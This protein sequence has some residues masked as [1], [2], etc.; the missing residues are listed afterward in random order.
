MNKKVLSLLGFASKAGKIGCGF[1][2]TLWSVKTKKA[3][4][5]VISD[6]ISEKSRKE[7]LFFAG[8]GNIKTTVLNGTDIQTI[9]NAVG[10][11]CGIVCVNDKGFADAILEANEV[12]EGGNAD[13]K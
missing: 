9:S 1:E 2:A 3:K 8:K 12:I 11:K 13:D 7:I 6:E 4:L 10:K 5:V